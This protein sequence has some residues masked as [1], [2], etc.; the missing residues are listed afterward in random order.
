MQQDNAYINYFNVMCLAMPH[1]K[2]KTTLT[3]DRT[4]WEPMLTH[5]ILQK[6]LLIHLLQRI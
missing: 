5:L 4:H 6:K 1:K 2:N 3:F